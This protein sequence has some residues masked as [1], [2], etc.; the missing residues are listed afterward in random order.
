MKRGEE[1]S[2]LPSSAKVIYKFKFEDYFKWICNEGF[3]YFQEASG[4]KWLFPDF[5]LMKKL[6]NVNQ[7]PGI[8][9][10]KL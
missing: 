3:S 4:P 9:T 5:K 1:S 10:D 7:T 2:H 6:I 8:T